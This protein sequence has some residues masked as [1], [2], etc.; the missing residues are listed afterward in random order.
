M[1]I[2]AVTL[3]A[4]GTLFDVAEPVGTTYARIAAAHGILVDA[5][6]ADRGFR[7]AF[8]SAPPMAFPGISDADRPARERAWWRAVV[9]AAFGAAAT[10]PAFPA[11]FDALFAHYA[12][13]RA[14]RVFP[15]IPGTLEALRARGL[16][17]AVVSNFD[18]RLPPLL[19]GLGLA[20]LVDAVVYS[21]AVGFAKPDPGIVRTAIRILG[22]AA[23]DTLHVGDGPGDVAAARG[24][25]AHAALLDRRGSGNAAPAGASVLRSLAALPALVERLTAHP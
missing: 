24:A 6:A 12:V 4:G 18:A 2:A 3:D 22:V 13:A 16:A 23:A 9:R 19:A 5:A 10:H 21:T 7:T 14:W 1:P 20:P 17:L 11:C 25:G 8:A 15:E